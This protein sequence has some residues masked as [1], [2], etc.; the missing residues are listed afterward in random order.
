MWIL[1]D[2]RMTTA[3][4]TENGG[5][6]RRRTEFAHFPAIL[7]IN[8]VAYLIRDIENRLSSTGLASIRNM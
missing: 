5:M 1:C 6:K 7:R 3:R 2:G 4:L 8:N